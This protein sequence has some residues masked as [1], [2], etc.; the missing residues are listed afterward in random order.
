MFVGYS[1]E[2]GTNL[3]SIIVNECKFHVLLFIKIRT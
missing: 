2:N 3:N 1:T